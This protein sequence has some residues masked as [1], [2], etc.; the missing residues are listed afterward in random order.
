MKQEERGPLSK[1]TRTTP[2]AAVKDPVDAVK[3]A[4][5]AKEPVAA[6][7]AGAKEP[8]AA[9]EAPARTKSDAERH[10]DDL[11][12]QMRS[13]LEEAKRR[14]GRLQRRSSS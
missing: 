12:N 1:K 13:R 7:K 3:A 11:Q 9:K 8:A 10:I 6:E 5:M 4:A 2:K 14:A